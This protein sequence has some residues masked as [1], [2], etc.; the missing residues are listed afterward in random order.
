MQTAISRPLGNHKPKIYKR[1]TQKKKQSK[2]NTKASDQT[3]RE[4]KR[5]GA[6]KRTTKTN[7]K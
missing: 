5:K 4:Q 2:H 6:N 3:T 1:F 7:P